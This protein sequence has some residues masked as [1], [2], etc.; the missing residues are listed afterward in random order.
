MSYIYLIRI[1]FIFYLFIIMVFL[2]IDTKNYDEKNEKDETPIVILNKFIK[3]GK[4]VFALI[5]MEG[6]GP[7]NATRPEWKKIENVL[8]SNM[9][10]DDFLI[11]DIDKD[12]LD[13]VDK[14]G[15]EPKGFPTIRYISN[16]G[17][18]SEDFE[19]SDLNEEY[20]DYIHWIRMTKNRKGTGFD[21]CESN[22]LNTP[23]QQIHYPICKYMYAKNKAIITDNDDPKKVGYVASRWNNLIDV[24]NRIVVTKPL[25]FCIND[26]Q[27]D[28]DKRDDTRNIVLSF[29]QH[30]YPNKPNFEK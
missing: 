8:K 19:D 7:C 14:I 1:N 5:Y 24:L 15:S 20:S 16:Y 22:S 21:V 27:L 9:N 25:F 12:V 18:T 3:D 2:H 10:D 28:I 17:K 30:Y 13:K 11:V 26:C 6:C 29:F 23:C 4:H